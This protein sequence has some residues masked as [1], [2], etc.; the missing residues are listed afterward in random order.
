MWL[1]MYLHEIKHVIRIHRVM[2]FK[3]EECYVHTPPQKL[4]YI[5]FS[6]GLYF[7]Y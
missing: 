3:Q 4:L 7:Q 2:K 1:F 5:Y 6:S